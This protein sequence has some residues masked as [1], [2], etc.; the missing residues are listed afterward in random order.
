MGLFDEPLKTCGDCKVEKPL[1]DFTKDSRRSD[2]LNRLCRSCCSARRR[3]HYLR[4]R[5]LEI[6]KA[7]EYRL[8]TREQAR[9]RESKRWRR[10][11][12]YMSNYIKERRARDP[13]FRIAANLRISVGKQ[14]RLIKQG[15][16]FSLTKSLGCTMNE[17]KS[18]IESRFTD[19]MSWD[20][21]GLWEIDH[22]KPLSL[23]ETVEDLKAMNHYT[24]LQPLWEKDNQ[25][26]SNNY[27]T[28]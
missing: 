15:K 14:C 11:K 21:Y 17:F 28:I 8:N 22:I 13:L 7:K 2:G 1:V 23:A 25:L 20:N 12:E 4:N 26:K 5:D 9:V 10:R 19:G 3:S 24:N 16:N 6:K 27:G 18:Y